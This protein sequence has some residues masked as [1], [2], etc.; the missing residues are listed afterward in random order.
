[1][2]NGYVIQCVDGEWSHSGGVSG[3]CSYHGGENNGGSPPSTSSPSNGSSTPA[4]PN[5]CDQNISTSSNVT[6]GL[7]ENT[8]YEYYQ[9]SGGDPTQP[10]TLQA[11]SS[12]TKRYYS[13]DCTGT[14]DVVDCT[15]GSGNDIQLITSGVS[16]YSADQAS[17]YAH[18]HDLGPNG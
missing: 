13:E 8:F 5:Q 7:A 3:A 11:W 14:G 4:L 16:A 10:V 6:C 18:S 17:S 2:T 15:F 9:A 12:A 1:M